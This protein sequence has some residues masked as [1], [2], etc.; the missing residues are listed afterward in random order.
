VLAALLVGCT[1]EL[2]VARESVTT[3]SEISQ[4]VTIYRDSMGVPHIFGE[5]A[6]DVLFAIG[7]TMAE[8]RLFQLETVRRAGMGE[9]AAL[10]GAD[11]VPADELARRDGY[12]KAELRAMIDGIEPT[13]RALLQSMVAGI[14]HYVD[15]AQADPEA[16]LPFE[17]EALDLPLRRYEDTDIIAAS[18]VILRLFGSAG[19][20]ELINQSFYDELVAR[21]GPEHARVI[22]DDV[23]VLSDPDAYATTADAKPAPSRQ[24]IPRFAPRPPS[25]G[26]TRATAERQ[27]RMRGTYRAALQELGLSLGASRSL[28]IA[29]SRSANGNV[30]MMQ[31]TADGHE[32]HVSGG[33]MNVAGLSIAPYGLPVMGR[34]RDFGWLITTGERDT[35]DTFVEKLNPENKYQYWYSGA[36]HDMDVRTETIEV[37]DADPVTLEVARTVHGPVIGWDLE[38]DTAY[39]QRWALWLAEAEIWAAGARTAQLESME[40]FEQ[41]LEADSLQNGNLSY[42]DRRGNVGVW[43]TGKL[44]VRAPGVD[45]RLP[46]PG[47]GEYEWRG[48]VPAEKMPR[49][50]NPEQGFLFVWNSKPAP[51]TLYGDAS[52]WGKHFRTH[53][54]ISLVE[55]EESLTVDDLKRINRTIAAGFGSVDLTIT[56]TRFFEPHWQSAIRDSDAAELR[57]A[58]GHMIDWNDLYHDEDSD[59]LYD[60]VGLTLFRSWLPLAQRTVFEDDL[61]EWWHKLDDDVYIKYRT[62]LLLRVLEGNQAGLPPKWDFLN[63]RSRDEVVRETLLQT[64]AELKE[65]FHGQPMSEWRQPVFWRYLSVGGAGDPDVSMPPPDGPAYLLESPASGAAVRL[66]YLPKAVRHNGLADWTTIMEFGD[67]PPRLLSVIPSGGQSWFINLGWKANPHIR[68]Q[69]QRHRDFDYKVVEMDK[70][71]ILKDL[72][73]TTVIRPLP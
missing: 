16:K 8:D 29:P 4:E 27:L 47:T 33:G 57:D 69:Y 30:L 73:S 60:H 58:V 40:E 28:T 64:L 6:K 24:A 15:E 32:V 37:A 70:E 46:T 31:T 72:E 49:L 54:P 44:P 48:Y 35:I 20:R 17:F 38:N 55:T 63:G 23:L 21:Y 39:S 66:G 10:F 3:S 50:K 14:N 51:D 41:R 7:Y 25:G 65:R 1:G 26:N 53:L 61:G 42:G 34:G 9:L 12:T 18:S 36:W 2:E 67:T 22:F 19:G 52:R 43:H 56:T 11:L 68:D 45:P 71:A 62:S 13:E 5:T 59:G